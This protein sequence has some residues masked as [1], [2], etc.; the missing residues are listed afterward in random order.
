M[1]EIKRVKCSK[2][3]G[4]NHWSMFKIWAFSFIP[5]YHSLK[6][7]TRYKYYIEKELPAIKGISTFSK[8][9]GYISIQFLWLV[10]SIDGTN[11]TAPDANLN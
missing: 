8:L 6:N 4:T 7:R 1:K 2:T 3:E 11:F 10:N 5:L 9:N